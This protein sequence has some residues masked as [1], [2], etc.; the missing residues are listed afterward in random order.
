MIEKNAMQPELQQVPLIFELQSWREYQ[1]KKFVIYLIQVL[2]VKS[3][4]IS[5]IEQL[6]LY[7]TIF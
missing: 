4:F 5:F 2:K 1:K 7:Q 3:Y 6:L